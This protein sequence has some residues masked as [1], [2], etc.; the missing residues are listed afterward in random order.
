[1]P[2]LAALSAAIG[3]LPASALSS[4]AS[5]NTLGF[6]YELIDLDRADSITP[7]ISFLYTV[8]TPWHI[9]QEDAT[10]Y[11]PKKG[12]PSREYS[13]ERD[14][15]KHVIPIA[16]AFAIS[17]L[18][19]ANAMAIDIPVIVEPDQIHDNTYTPPPYRADDGFHHLAAGDTFDLDYTFNQPITIKDSFIPSDESIHIVVENAAH[20]EHPV[21]TPGTVI[22][23]VFTLT[24]AT[25]AFTGT[26]FSDT[27]PAPGNGGA[28]ELH[29]NDV[30]ITNGTM[31]FRDLHLKLSVVAGN[32]NFST[33]TLGVDADNVSSVPEPHTYMLLLGGM[34]VIALVR[35]NLAW[36]E[37]RTKAP[38]TLC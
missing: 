22:N 14:F 8:R 3:F 13:F 20:V 21:V 32:L 26:S 2:A 18:L 27:L 28:I 35:R 34:A 10:G 29:N 24:G 15:M 9:A 37:S 33:V 23:Y 11:M 6:G 1:L 25:G 5:A 17:S 7:T 36:R 31:S 12:L 30:E 16:T 19:S 4:S 38:V